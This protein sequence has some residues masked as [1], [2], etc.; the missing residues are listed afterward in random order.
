MTYQ[1]KYSNETM[2]GPS[3]EVVKAR[4]RAAFTHRCGCGKLRDPSAIH[5]IGS[6]TWVS[7]L[8]CLGTIKQLS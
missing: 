1:D 7:C 4:H 3:L 6:R 2:L 8:R 5:K